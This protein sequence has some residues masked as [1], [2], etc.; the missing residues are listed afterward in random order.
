[1]RTASRTLRRHARPP[2]TGPRITR[3]AKDSALHV[4]DG[5]TL[6]SYRSGVHLLIRYDT[7]YSGN[8][9]I[10]IY[11]FSGTMDRLHVI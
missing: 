10:Y 6:R 5:R 4:P 11:T 2:S 8:I 7:I 9:Y 1:M 3:D